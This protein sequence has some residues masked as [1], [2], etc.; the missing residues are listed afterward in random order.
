[1][2]LPHVTP[3]R[4][5]PYLLS[6]TSEVYILVRLWRLNRRVA[7]NEPAHSFLF[8]N[9]DVILALT[10]IPVVWHIA[11]RKKQPRPRADNPDTG[12]STDYW[13]GRPS[14]AAGVY[15]PAPQVR[16]YQT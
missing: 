3:H 4:V 1:M 15:G 8:K 11:Q 10:G 2:A 14:I 12:G 6:G 13:A 16:S 9:T 5:A 7:D